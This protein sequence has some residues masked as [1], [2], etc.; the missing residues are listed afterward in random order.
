MRS[1]FQTSQ[2]RRV[3]RDIHLQGANE[4]MTL[5]TSHLHEQSLFAVEDFLGQRFNK[6]LRRGRN[7]RENVDDGGAEL[8]FGSTQLGA[9]LLGV[10]AVLEP[11]LQMF[12]QLKAELL[13]EDG[14]EE[15]RQVRQ[16]LDHVQVQI[17]KIP[18]QR[19]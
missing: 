19:E 16:A 13:V 5:T 12:P 15:L 4:P 7:Q 3:I 2:T 10:D 9:R 6:L 8:E 14:G 1:A 11:L 17:L 18:Q